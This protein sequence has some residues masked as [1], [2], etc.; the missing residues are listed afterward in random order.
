M[1]KQ[2]WLPLDMIAKSVQS[3]S[4]AQ[5]PTG[6]VRYPS[7]PDV[8]RISVWLEARATILDEKTKDQMH[9]ISRLARVG[10]AVGRPGREHR[11]RW[12]RCLRT[13]CREYW[14]ELDQDVRVMLSRRALRGSG[15]W[16]VRGSARDGAAVHPFC[17]KWFPTAKADELDL[18]YR[19]LTWWRQRNPRLRNTV[20][21]PVALWSD[22][23]ALLM[24]QSRG[25][26][27]SRFLERSSWRDAAPLSELDHYGV[28]L[29]G[30]LRAFA[31]V[32]E[33]F[34]V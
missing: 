19:R 2:S 25:E 15:G 34:F 12:L 16:V 22:E 13:S 1:A 6:G 9:V 31:A 21:E 17:I 33:A 4:I 5:E 23:N 24:G 7:R 20:A 8:A 28:K 11:R 18:T 10:K 29:G 32:N 30:W 27:L 3:R 26:R 14:P